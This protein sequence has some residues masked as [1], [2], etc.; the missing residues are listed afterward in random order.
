MNTA[1]TRILP[2]M[3]R[4][5]QVA[6][7]RDRGGHAIQSLSDHIALSMRSEIMNVTAAIMAIFLLLAPDK[8]YVKPEE[9]VMVRFLQSSQPQ[10]AKDVEVAGLSA[11]DLPDLFTKSGPGDIIGEGGKPLFRL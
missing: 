9:P 7:R 4:P 1:K 6:N 11:A 3:G 10:A 5:I 2:A 8:A